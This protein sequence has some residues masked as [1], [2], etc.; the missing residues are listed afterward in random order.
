MGARI[1][2]HR[3]QI[4][5]S[6]Y[7][8][9]PAASDDVGPHTP[10]ACGLQSSASHPRVHHRFGAE[11][12]PSSHRLLIRRSAQSTIIGIM[13]DGS[14][15]VRTRAAGMAETA[16]PCWEIFRSPPPKKNL[17]RVAE[18]GDDDFFD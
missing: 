17:I 1:R 8:S 5:H 12:S 16:S 3:L 14:T 13:H 2:R 4:L 7:G 18:C 9:I 10:S 11:T 6:P 15:S